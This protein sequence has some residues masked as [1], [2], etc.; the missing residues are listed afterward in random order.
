MRELIN[1]NDDHATIRWKLLASASA[2]VLGACLASGD[3]AFA[4]SDRPVIWIEL[5][6]QMESL[7]GTSSPFTA[8]FM[9]LTPT[10]DPYKN[11]GS[12]ISE[13]KP[14]LYAFGESG[15]ITYQPEDSDWVFSAS[16]LFGRSHSNRHAH[17]Q[18]AI[19]PFHFSFSFYGS[20]YQYTK[21]FGDQLFADTHQSYH[22]KHALIDFQAGKDVGLGRF[23]TSVISVGVRYASLTA[24]S[25]LTVYARPKNGIGYISFFGISFPRQTFYEY[26]MHGDAQ[27]SFKAIGPI[28]SWN[29]SATIAGTPDRGELTLDWSLDGAL[30]FGRNRT[31]THH[32][33]QAYHLSAALYATYPIV[34]QH[35]LN[36]SRSHRVTVPD[37]GASIGLSAEF[38]NAK[39]SVGYRLE[40]LFGAFDK[41]IDTE[42]KSDLTFNGPYASISIGLGD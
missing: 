36:A 27:R 38:K 13:Q 25:Q 41:G 7:S 15:K 6:G 42:K 22:E 1:I 3:A 5:G 8:P 34:Y 16:M 30:L 2:L 32:D 23:G 14:P 33:T 29:A 4:D 21:Y 26:T 17:H 37:L 40:R 19:P 11:G 18:T 20:V 12:P 39:I 10:P 31:R 35:S 24:N 28:V 9:L